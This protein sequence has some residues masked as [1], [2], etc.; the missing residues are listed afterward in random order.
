M[1]LRVMQNR[2]VIKLLYRTVDI[3]TCLRVM[4]NRI[5]IKPSGR[6]VLRDNEFES[7]V[8]SYSYKTAFMQQYTPMQFES[9]VESYSYKTPTPSD[10]SY[11]QFESNVE[12]YSYKTQIM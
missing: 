5:V 7:N 6:P 3:L 1:R 2:I 11:T 12:S 9:N 8:E 10:R 4:Q